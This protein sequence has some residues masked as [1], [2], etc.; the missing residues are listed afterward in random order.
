[1]L[2]EVE[3]RVKSEVALDRVEF[4]NQILHDIKGEREKLQ[5]ATDDARK[6]LS[7]QKDK[8]IK[9]I[10]QEFSLFKQKYS[11]LESVIASK[12]VDIDFHT[13]DDAHKLVEQLHIKKPDGYIN[14][15]KKNN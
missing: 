10:E 9:E 7:A 2:K 1:M 11:W 14:I 5:S 3:S 12:E 15:V 13:I 6:N 8:C 4:S